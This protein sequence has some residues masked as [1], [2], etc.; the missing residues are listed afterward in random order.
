VSNSFPKVSP[1][2][3]WIVYVQATNGL[4]MRPDGKLYMVPFEGGKPRLMNCNTP[5]MNSWH[6]FSPNGRWMVFSSKSRS[7]Y[8]QMFLTHIDESGH[9]SPPI[10]IE[11]ATAANR[12]V[13]IPEFV[14]IGMDDWLKLE[15][16]ATDF[17][18]QSDEAFDL[19][20]KGQHD[21]ALA[22]FRKLVEIEP[23]DT[24]A[25]NNLG[26]ALSETGQ[27][28]QAVAQF[29]KVL[30]IDPDN[31]KAY[32]NLG[33]ALGRIGKFEEA[34]AQFEQALSISPDDA[35]THS[36]F[37]AVLFNSGRADAAMPHLEKALDLNPG[38]TDARNNLGGILA[39]SGR[40]DEAIPHF[41]K[42]LE[43]EPA[44]MELNFNLGRALA[45]AGKVS[46]GI[47]Y[48]E[49]AVQ[50]GGSSNALVLD[51]LSGIYAAAGRV[52]DA[53]STARRALS[54]TTDPQAAG[55]LRERIAQY[56][57]AAR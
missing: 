3:K 17:Y 21:K 24:A 47:P 49:K 19:L 27:F 25:L 54:L 22:E 46:E 2:G 37:G 44:S 12:A 32:S 26:S 36:A 39:R 34:A 15:A 43:I 35:R 8:T 30:S 31:Y 41:R 11:N 7:P 57:A 40:F 28:D 52:N 6:S 10:L 16:P 20:T 51:R 50:L 38:D 14:N 18:R 45:A 53:L 9:D 55:A 48:V 1:D 33:V 5:L 13:N 29:R 4:L 56:E 42:A 23:D